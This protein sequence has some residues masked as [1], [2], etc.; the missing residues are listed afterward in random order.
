MAAGRKA[1]RQ[2]RRET[3]LEELAPAAQRKSVVAQD[4]T[5]LRE[6]VVTMSTWAEPGNTT[7]K[8]V[9][10]YRRT[11][12]LLTLHQRGELI[13]NNH[14]I[15]AD[16][17]VR[18][19]EVGMEGGRPGYD[20]LLAIQS[21]FHGVEPSRM[22]LNALQRLRAANKSVGTSLLPILHDVV[23]K[24]T[25]LKDWAQR[26]RVNAQVALGR[27]VATLDRLSDHYASAQ[28]TRRQN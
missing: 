22:R 20:R 11:D 6:P 17:Y 3:R 5:V 21:G 23:V 1:L 8:L 15:I 18:D 9:T 14:L 25:T 16:R 26:N 28:S 7:T 24:N 4:G 10:G 2:I 12:S 27:L 19:Y 13:T